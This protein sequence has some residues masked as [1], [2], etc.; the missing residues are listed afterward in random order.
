MFL[1]FEILPILE[2]LVFRFSAYRSDYS[3]NQKCWLSVNLIKSDALNRNPRIFYC[4][5]KKE[6]K[7]KKRKK[8]GRHF[9]SRVLNHSTLDRHIFN[10]STFRVGLINQWNCILLLC[11]FLPVGIVKIV[12]MAF[13]IHLSVVRVWLVIV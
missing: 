9:F 12:L 13:I 2:K 8:K 1:N 4:L 11:H 5:Q 7:E 6:K 10:T 3:D